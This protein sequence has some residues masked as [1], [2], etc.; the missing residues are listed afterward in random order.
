MEKITIP[1]TRSN[2]ITLPPHLKRCQRPGE[3]VWNICLLECGV[4]LLVIE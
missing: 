3:L 4:V 2:R 1:R